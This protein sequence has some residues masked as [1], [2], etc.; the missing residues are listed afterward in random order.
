M[1]ETDVTVETSE[2]KLCDPE[3]TRV[4]LSIQNTHDSA[5]IKITSHSGESATGTRIYPEDM[6]ILHA[7]VGDQTHKAWYAVSDTAG[8]TV[9][10]HEVFGIIPDITPIP[11]KKEMN[12]LPFL[13]L[14]GLAGVKRR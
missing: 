11:E 3:K 7:L 14:A 2:T 9:N 1:P 12:M 10:V 6:I 8:V 13:A 4:I 5:V